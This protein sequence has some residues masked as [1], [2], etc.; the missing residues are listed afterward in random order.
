ME[1]KNYLRPIIYVMLNYDIFNQY[2]KLK[3]F[4]FHLS[5]YKCFCYAVWASCYVTCF[6][7]IIAF[8]YFTLF[9]FLFF[10]KCIIDGSSWHSY[11]TMNYF[12]IFFFCIYICFFEFNGPTFK[13]F[14]QSL[15]SA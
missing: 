4:I 13:I 9:F 12:Y 15:T 14:P 3:N 10:Y 8:V 5:I 6:Y 7:A 2:Y 1:T 11:R